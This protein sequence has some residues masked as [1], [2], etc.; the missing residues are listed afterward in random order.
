LPGSS[1]KARRRD[2]GGGPRFASLRC[3]S[4]IQAGAAHE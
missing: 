4:F 1:E 3:R 2:N